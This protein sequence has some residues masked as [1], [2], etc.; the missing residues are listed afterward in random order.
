MIRIKL[1]VVVSVLALAIITFVFPPYVTVN[2][3]ED[4]K[5][6]KEKQVGYGRGGR[7]QAGSPSEHA[8]EAIQPIPLSFDYDRA[9]VE[10]GKKLFFE[11]RLSKS[12]WISCNSCH[13]LS[14]GGADNLPSSIG[15][16]WFLGPIN[17]PTV[18]NSKFNL[19]QF[20][21]GRA[22]DLQ[23]QAGGPIANPLEMASNHELA[24]NILQ[25]IPQYVQWFEE[26][27]GG[28]ELYGSGK[29][30]IL[31]VTDA[32]AAFEETL[33]TPG[34][35]F[36][37]WLNGYGDAITDSEKEGYEL[38]K[39]KGCITCHNGMGVGGNSYQKFGLAKPYDKDPH[40]Q[41]RYDVTKEEKDKFVFKVPLL[42]NIEL[43]APYFHDASTWDLSEAVNV[44]TEYQLGISLSNEEN[45][46]IVAFLKTLTGEQPQIVLPILPPS[47]KATPQPNRN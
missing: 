13:N 31:K 40:T 12:G 19:A 14:T 47:T 15:H 7:V 32:I 27:Y 25:S 1:G 26:V 30:D 42:R 11:P 4:Q 20:W 41:G 44:M 8:K 29:I 39:T 16:K 35:R 2:A 22:K 43:T 45:E 21:D 6:L 37:Q 28:K 23:E 34:S 3:S 36:D 46:K 5:T 38:F 24:I 33:T 18:L 17:S 10:L 9:K